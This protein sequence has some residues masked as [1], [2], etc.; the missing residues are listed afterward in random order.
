[1][2][3]RFERSLGCK[4]VYTLKKGVFE[5]MIKRTTFDPV[6]VRPSTSI[7]SWSCSIRSLDIEGTSD[8]MSDLSQILFLT[9]SNEYRR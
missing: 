6:Y 4:E 2:K 7:L 1:M 5:V 8:I 9:H 3:V